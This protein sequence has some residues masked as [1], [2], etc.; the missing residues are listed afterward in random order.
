MGFGINK[1]L[2]FLSPRI[3]YSNI[4]RR[5]ILNR[6]K[7]IELKIGLGCVIRNVRFGKSVYLADNVVLINSSVGTHTYINAFTKITNAEIG[8][9]C[10][11]AS[12]VKIVLGYHPTH[13]VTLHPA[14][15]S[16]NKEFETFSDQNYFEE[17]PKVTLGNDVWIGE[18]A[19]IMG[20]ITVG[21]GAVIAARAVVTKD[22][23]PYSVVGGVP[24]KFIKARF[25]DEIINKLL[26]IRWWDKEEDWIRNNYLLFHDPEVF[27]SQLSK[28]ALPHDL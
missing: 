3:L 7:G 22:V 9:Y 2:K 13:L 12:G 11:I 8:N 14:F 15:Y 10:S 20:G 17:Y 23:P 28:N 18:D 21:D 27:V 5:K 4:V 25:T 1:L 6:Y 24:A 26:K 19:I 16:N